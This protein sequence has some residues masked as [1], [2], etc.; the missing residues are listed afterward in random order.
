LVGVGVGRAVVASVT[1][2]I[3]IAVG[4]VRVRVIRAIV[5]IVTYTIAVGVLKQLEG[6]QVA[7]GALG[8]G[9]TSLILVQAETII[10]GIN[11]IAAGLQR[12]R[13]G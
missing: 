3:G 6:A 8:T 4:L 13:L 11:R 9:D 2:A 7:R 5:L 1:Q 10:A 12:D